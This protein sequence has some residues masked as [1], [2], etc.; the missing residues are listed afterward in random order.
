MTAGTLAP[1]LAVFLLMLIATTFASNHIAA[2]IAFDHGLSVTAA[3]MVR[4]C[5][6]ALFVYTLLR[7]QGVPMA[8][9]RPQLLRTLGVGVLIAIQS[10]C[11]Y[12]A[13]ARI[14]VAFALLAFNTYPMIL[15]LV[16]WIAGGDRPSRRAMVAMPIALVGLMF[17]LDAFGHAGDIARRWTEIG[18]GV[19]WALGAAFSF[20]L[21]LYFSASS[22]R[23]VDGR[24]R[25]LYTMPVVAVLVTAG[26]ALT[27]SLA[28]PHDTPGWTGLAILTLFYGSAITALFVV[29]PRIRAV[30]T[31]VALNF[32]PIAALI[33]GWL[34][35]GQS[36]G[37]LQIFGAFVVIGA[38]IYIGSAKQ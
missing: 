18:T 25:T 31:A 21:V 36:V 5:C 22:L 15:A 34:I 1:R 14:Y 19:G 6:T 10:Y 17:A 26:G 20:A 35:L 4:S 37:P 13:V 9:K 30:N 12:A 32:E 38:I 33:L 24:L 7:V 16:S 2:R 3:V 28:L 29:L 11:L 8:L 27:G 23:D